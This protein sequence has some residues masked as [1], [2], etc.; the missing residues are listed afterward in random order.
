MGGVL[1]TFD[2]LTKG[3]MGALGTGLI[4]A[5]FL[6]KK[7]GHTA[8][9]TG[10]FFTEMSLSATGLG[11]I[12]SDALGVAKGLSAELGGIG[13]A[14]F[15]AQLQTNLL[16]NNLHISSGEAVSLMGSFS[17]L[18][19]NSTDIAAST[20]QITKNLA[21]QNGVIPAQVMADVEGQFEAQRHC[22]IHFKTQG[23]QVHVELDDHGL[24]L[25]DGLGDEEQVV[26]EAQEV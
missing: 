22:K 10:T 15:K 1:E 8:H 12:F 3:P 9:E 17:R 24:Q 7:L 21:K 13:E 19:G 11:F 25:V 5:G 16:A 6:L 18:N 2:T 4:G 26:G 20:I 23:F 14:G